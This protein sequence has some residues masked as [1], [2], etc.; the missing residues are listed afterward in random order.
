MAKK[1]SKKTVSVKKVDSQPLI[2]WTPTRQVLAAAGFFFILILIYFFPIVFENKIP[3]SSD[4]IAWKGNAHSILEAR[5]QYSY[6]PLWANNVFSG[7]PA[8]LISLW[9][10]FEQPAR[11]LLDGLAWVI[12]WQA[13]YYLIGAFGMILLMRTLGVSILA[14]SF[15][16]LAFV[17][18]PN[19]VGL[20]EAGHNG[21]VQ[22]ILLM[23]LV[24][25]LFLRWMRKANLLNFLLFTIG[26]SLA[27]RAGHYQIVF[28]LVL[29][30]FFFGLVEVYRLD[31]KSVV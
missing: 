19:L 22:T 30:L 28:Y 26:F 9:P 16:A 31:R 14:A 7:M 17:W 29:A 5:K 11:Y 27:V 23:P 6:T 12:K 8:H 13:L 10:P 3:P 15:S 4:I 1:S 20:L 21:K 25:F 2:N 18:W 24:I